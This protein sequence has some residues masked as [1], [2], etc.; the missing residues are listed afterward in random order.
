MAQEKCSLQLRINCT[1]AIFG[2]LLAEMQEVDAGLATKQKEVAELQ[3]ELESQL[4]QDD[5]SQKDADSTPM[6]IEE[7]LGISLT[8]ANQ[9]VEDEEK[10]TS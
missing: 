4:V 3:K 2:D 5:T 1:K 10:A 7:V 8:R 9:G 6:E